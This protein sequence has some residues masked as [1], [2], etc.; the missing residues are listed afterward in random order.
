MV[1]YYNGNEVRGCALRAPALR[2]V[3]QFVCS[4]VE[5]GET[6]TR[7]SH[8]APGVVVCGEFRGLAVHGSQR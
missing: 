4:G 7:T 8:W 5:S 1:Y 2:A 3:Y 6:S